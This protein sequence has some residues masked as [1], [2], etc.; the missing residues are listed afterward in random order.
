MLLPLDNK[1]IEQLP[2]MPLS[3]DKSGRF[4]WDTDAADLF[5]CP[6][7]NLCMDTDTGRAPR[8]L[9]QVFLPS[10]SVFA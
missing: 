8:V 6:N 1:L 10:L 3:R 2:S 4:V 7:T 5:C 9:L